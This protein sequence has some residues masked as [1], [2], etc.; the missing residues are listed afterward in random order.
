MHIKSFHFLKYLFILFIYFWLHWVFVAACG[1]SLVA[2]SRGYSSLQCAGFSLRWL[3]LL[4]S[5]GSRCMGFSSCGAWAQQL[6]LAGSRAQAQQLQRTG[7][8]ALQHV[9]C[10]QTRARTRVPCVGR[11]ILNHCAT[12]EAQI[13]SFLQCLG[14]VSITVLILLVRKPR[15]PRFRQIAQSHIADKG[16][17]Q[18][19]NLDSVHSL[20]LFGVLNDLSFSTCLLQKRDTSSVESA[21]INMNFIS[22]LV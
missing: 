15:L 7:L 20:S 3:L 14:K 9:G 18:N 5:T 16:Q 10:S 1:L 13:I 8:V 12:R 4:R 17:K 2:V 19:S 11:R 22:S 6:W 21:H